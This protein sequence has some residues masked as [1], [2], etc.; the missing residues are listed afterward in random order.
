MKPPPVWQMPLVH[1]PRTNPR[2]MRVRQERDLQTNGQRARPR[3]DE[4]TV[5]MEHSPRL[6]V[7]SAMTPLTCVVMLRY[8][9]VV[10]RCLYPWG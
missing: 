9:R 3:P 2:T 5:G 10:A 7:G 6:R 4:T 8:S 1:F